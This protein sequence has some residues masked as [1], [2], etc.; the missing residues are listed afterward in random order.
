M[1]GISLPVM[2]VFFS[3]DV[4]VV[5]VV[6]FFF[7]TFWYADTP[8]VSGVLGAYLF[9]PQQI[10]LSKLSTFQAAV[11]FLIPCSWRSFRSL[12]S[13][14]RAPKRITGRQLGPWWLQLFFV[15][16]ENSIFSMV[17]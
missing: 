10:L 11:T 14:Q 3:R 13:C 8:I 2:S 12:K 17:F 7:Y 1:V 16:R 4:D 5:V 9:F 6:V 15:H